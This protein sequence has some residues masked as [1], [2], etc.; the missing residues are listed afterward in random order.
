MKVFRG[1]D[2]I[3]IGGPTAVTVGTFD[4]VH[5]GHQQVLQE[6]NH[7]PDEIN[8]TTVLVTF[9]PHPKTVVG[10][11]PGQKILLLTT[12]E[13]KLEILQHYGLDAVV[14]IPFT[15]EFAKTGYRDFVRHILVEK[16]HV[17]KMVVGYD[18]TFGRNR[19]GHPEQLKEIAATY[20]FSVT[21]LNPY[22]VSG[23]VDSSTL[24]RHH[25]QEGRIADANEL[26]GHRYFLHGRV[27]SGDQRGRDL[28]FPTANLQVDDPHKLI[29][30]RGVYAVDVT[31]GTKRYPGMMNIGNRPTFNFDPL[32]LEVHIF[33]FSGSI[34][35][36]N[37]KIDFKKF[38]REEKKFSDPQEL[39][40][41]LEE[42]KRICINI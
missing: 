4:G 36:E 27:E 31:V 11:K 12:L 37:I 2:Q 24:I 17:R 13:E 10:K 33:K 30:K 5:R 18:H 26:L 35:G 15:R 16:L 20:G 23:K 22:S 14:V 29:P 42:D 40:R 6:L 8:C 3:D 41:Q 32:T 9:H 1:I 7:C 25:L 34:Y 19:E 39:K 21:V 28:G 38:I